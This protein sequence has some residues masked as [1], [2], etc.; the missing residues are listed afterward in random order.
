[1]LF[2]TSAK[3]RNILFAIVSKRYS[4]T[5]LPKTTGSVSW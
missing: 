1:M 2:V 3:I 5:P 4:I